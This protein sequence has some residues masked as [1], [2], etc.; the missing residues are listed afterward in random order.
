MQK[1]TGIAANFRT[2]T[3]YPE[4]SDEEDPDEDTRW[5][6]VDVATLPVQDDAK[7]DWRPDVK[8]AQLM[9]RPMASMWMKANELYFSN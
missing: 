8:S 2:C 7:E 5:T 9:T 3:E 4:S 1:V 6:E